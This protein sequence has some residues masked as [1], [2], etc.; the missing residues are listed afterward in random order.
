MS[1]HEIAERLSLAFR[2][3]AEDFIAMCPE[4]LSVSID[5][6]S[7]MARYVGYTAHGNR[8]SLPVR[9]RAIRP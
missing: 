6:E 9:E 7:L 8:P 5:P 3:M 4:M 2:V 1:D